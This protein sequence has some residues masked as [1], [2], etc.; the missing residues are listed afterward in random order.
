MLVP[1][2]AARG[3]CG[4]CRQRRT[5][6]RR[7]LPRP[8]LDQRPRARRT[9][10]NP[11][12]WRILVPRRFG[13][14]FQRLLTAYCSFAACCNHTH[15][16]QTIRGESLPPRP[17]QSQP[18]TVPAF[19]SS[20][21]PGRPRSNRKRRRRRCCHCSCRAAGER[22]CV[23]AGRSVV[24]SWHRPKRHGS[25]IQ[26]GMPGPALAIGCSPPASRR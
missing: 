17:S 21:S 12:I 26:C 3:S 23:S 19:F 11:Y 9:S 13:T 5:R 1:R 15:D 18:P 7:L 24:S 6:D 2:W 22:N 10:S 20:P 4:R 8:A 25:I 16:Q 14:G